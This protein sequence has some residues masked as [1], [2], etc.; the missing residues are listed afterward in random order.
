MLIMYFFNRNKI[1]LFKKQISEII[2]LEPNLSKIQAILVEPLDLL[3][4][5]M[6][7]FK[8][9]EGDLMPLIDLNREKTI[10]FV[11]PDLEFIKIAKQSIYQYI[12]IGYEEPEQILTKF[13]EFSFL[14]NRS[15]P[16]ILKSVFGESKEE[17][18]IYNLNKQQI[19]NKL[20]E[21]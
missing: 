4:K 15:I 21:Y 3:I 1:F 2:F 20:K 6:K 14:V 12:A 16:Q 19:E 13:S 18:L 17:I 8:I 5:T 10:Y 11:E 7:K 9:L